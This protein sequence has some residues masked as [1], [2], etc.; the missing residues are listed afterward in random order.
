MIDEYKEY[1]EA[2]KRAQAIKD[3]TL[4]HLDH[5]LEMFEANATANGAVVHWARTPEDA[6]RIVAQI[7][8]EANA[9]TATRVKS[10]LGEEIGIGEALAEAG[11]ERIETDL[12]EHIIQLA[13]DPPSHIV[14]PAMH[15]THEQVAEL[16]DLKHG[17]APDSHEI[18]DLVAS[19]RR[20]LR[21]K[22]LDADVGI[23]GANFLIAETGAIVTVTNE[24][25]SELTCT[26]PKVHIVTAGIE[27]I[28]PG[29][30][31]AS[32]SSQ[33][34]V[35]RRHWGRDHAIHDLLQRAKT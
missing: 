28:V 15:K 33:A 24:G 17:I 5:Y 8:T 21:R 12:A 25:N 23:S 1:G 9:R 13:K 27:K 26:P 2:R 18:A 29:M 6:R 35:A 19:A 4:R 22:F 11:I 34:F 7:C 32:V 20:E 10:M 31:H 14:M 16:F 3:H 30:D